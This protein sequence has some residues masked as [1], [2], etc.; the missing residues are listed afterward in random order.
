MPKSRHSCATFAP[1]PVAA[2]TNSLF[3]SMGRCSF[4]G[5]AQPYMCHRCL[6]LSVSPMSCPIPLHTLPPP[7]P[8]LRSGPLAAA[9]RLGQL[10]DRLELVL[11]VGGARRL[12]V[13]LHEVREQR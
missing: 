10:G 2:R 3:N 11:G 7:P 6:V 8:D 1:G 12:R 5:I 4:H 9:G 13:A